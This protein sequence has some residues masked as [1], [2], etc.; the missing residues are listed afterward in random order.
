MELPSASPSEFAPIAPASAK[1]PLPVLL[2]GAATTAAALAVHEI[3]LRF[4]TNLLG[5]Q[6]NYVLPLGAMGLGLLASIGFCAAAYVTGRRVTGPLL[7]ASAAVLVAGYFGLQYYEYRLR[8]PDGLAQ[9]GSQLSFWDYYEW[10][11]RSLRYRSD[12]RGLGGPLGAWGFGVR[13]LQVCGFALMGLV[14][15]LTLRSRSYCGP[16]G[17]YRRST[18]LGLIQAGIPDKVFGNDSPERVA[19]RAARAQQGEA[20]LQR[21]VGLVSAGDGP[22]ATAALAEAA[23]RAARKQADAAN[24][25][26]SLALAHCPRCREGEL[27][28]TRVTGQGKQIR[29]ERLQAVAANAPAVEALLAPQA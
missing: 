9:D 3:A 25:R 18:E 6:A 16:C 24:A 5:M 22:G 27:I 26:L 12:K 19:E 15:L 28:V 17:R 8:F 23:P 2:A 7:L 21:I 10:M 11:A 14:P 20:A 29:R 4:D 13:A 1:G